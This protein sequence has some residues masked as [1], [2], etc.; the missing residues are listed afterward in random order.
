MSIACVYRGPSAT[1]SEDQQTI[2]ALDNLARNSTRLFVMGDFNLRYGDWEL[3]RCPRGSGEIYL[4]WIQS[5]ALYQHVKEN[6]RY[7]EVQQPSLLDLIITVQEEEEQ[8]LEYHP[9]TGKSDHFL[10]KRTLQ[11]KFAKPREEMCWNTGR[12]DVN[13]L[14][15]KAAQ[16]SWHSSE[17]TRT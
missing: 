9:P 7:R 13:L 15:A 8:S 3:G 5:Q 14:Q 10:I 11:L 6:T 4:E 2:Q 17:S 12:I 16:L 1:H